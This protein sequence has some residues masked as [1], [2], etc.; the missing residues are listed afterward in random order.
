MSIFD[1]SPEDNITKEYLIKKGFFELIDDQIYIY[2]DDNG[3]VSYRFDNEWLD[4]VVVDRH[5][6]MDTH[7]QC[8]G[9]RSIW[10]RESYKSDTLLCSYH[11]TD[12]G[13]FD[14]LFNDFKKM[15]NHLK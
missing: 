14:V 4:L 11:I 9:V 15:T 5:M 12:R 3:V 10:K 6:L 13:L 8:L 1:I 2:F 7:L